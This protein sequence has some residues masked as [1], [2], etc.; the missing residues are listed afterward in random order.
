M[1]ATLVE[2]TELLETVLASTVAG[3]GVT[4]VFSMGIWG[5]AR[6]TDLSREER[7]LASGLAAAVA[8]LSLLGTVAIV[9]LGVIVM[10]GK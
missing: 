1:I 3:I 6:S 2:G 8:A 9:V 7:R 5:V 4:F 10:T